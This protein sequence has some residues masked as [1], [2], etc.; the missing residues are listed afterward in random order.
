[1]LAP[2]NGRALRVSGDEN[3]K[4]TAVLVGR[5][6][7]SLPRGSARDSQQPKPKPKY[8]IV[9]HPAY[10]HRDNPFEVD[11]Q[12]FQGFDT[13]QATNRNYEDPLKN[14][15]E[16]YAGRMLAASAPVESTELFVIA[17]QHYNEAIK[18]S[19]ILAKYLIL[20]GIFLFLGTI[21]IGAA[22]VYGGLVG[23]GTS[24]PKRLNN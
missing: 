4:L 20:G 18:Q 16:E 15:D 12:G 10:Q 19:E 1:M 3:S 21:I 11:L 9:I 14:R 7:Q 2:K 5:W 8:L 17:Q 6:D 23:N 24:S 13:K 22:V